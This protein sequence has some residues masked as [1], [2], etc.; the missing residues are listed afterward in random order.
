LEIVESSKLLNRPKEAAEGS[1][2]AKA[3]MEYAVENGKKIIFLYGF[4]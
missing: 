2:G 4:E 3:E 1:K